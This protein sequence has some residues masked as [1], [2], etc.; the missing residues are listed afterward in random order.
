[1]WSAIAAPVLAPVLTPVLALVLAGT[2]AGCRSADE[3]ACRVERG[4]NYDACMYRTQ[5]AHW[6]DRQHD[7]VDQP[8][9][10]RGDQMSCLRA[11]QYEKARSAGFDHQRKFQSACDASIAEACYEAGRGM[12]GPTTRPRG[13][14]LIY[15]SCEMG[16]QRACQDG[17]GLAEQGPERDR[18]GV[19]ACQRG[20]AAA[21]PVPQRP[22]D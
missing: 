19:L 22:A 6:E 8:A 20:V 15:R 11:A 12:L 17:P 16:F 3:F 18:F 21:C 4:G 5:R 2:G 7:E 14:Q 10:E 1:M 13:M 9:C